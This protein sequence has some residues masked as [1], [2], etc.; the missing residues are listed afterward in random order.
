MR[1]RVP[2]SLSVIVVILMLI[3]RFLSMR[4]PNTQNYVM[5]L[6]FHFYNTFVKDS[7]LIIRTKMF[8]MLFIKSQEAAIPAC[9]KMKIKKKSKQ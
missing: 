1:L 4:H 2:L 3:R 6:A 5:I 8:S 9:K 7:F